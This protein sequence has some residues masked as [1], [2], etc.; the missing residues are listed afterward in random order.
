MKNRELVLLVTCNQYGD[1]YTHSNLPYMIVFRYR[2]TWVA[3]QI[4][5]EAIEVAKILQRNSRAGFY[6]GFVIYNSAISV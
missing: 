2:M 5:R 4:L 3:R 6:C 1:E